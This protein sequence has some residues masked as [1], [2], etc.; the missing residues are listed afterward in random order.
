MLPPWQWAPCWDF[1]E[2]RWMFN[3]YLPFNPFSSFHSIVFWYAY[4]SPHMD[5]LKPDRSYLSQSNET[6]SLSFFIFTFISIQMDGLRE[7]RRK[8]KK[9]TQ[10]THNKSKIKNWNQ[11]GDARVMFIVIHILWM[12][13][14]ARLTNQARSSLKRGERENIL[15]LWN[16][17]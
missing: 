9:N 8:Q 13:L 16:F 2:S 3:V 15:C 17:L 11:L 10:C 5:L 14:Q 7:Q 12:S 6:I 1:F 4:I